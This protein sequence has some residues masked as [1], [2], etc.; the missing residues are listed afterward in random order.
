MNNRFVIVVAA[1][2]ILF[3]G[4][5]YLTKHKTTKNSGSTSN[6]QPSSHI[7]GTGSKNVTLIEYGDYECPACAAYY[8][9]LKQMVEKNK[10]DI[11]FQFRNFPLYQIHQNAFAGARA[12]EAA[13]I[14][15]KYFEM[16]DLLYENQQSWVSSSNPS[17]FFDMYAQQLGLDI[18]KFKQ[19]EA[20]DQTNNVINADI[21]AGVASGTD[22]TPTF[23]LDG[24]KIDNNP[25]DVTSFQKLIDD[26]IKA[27][28]TK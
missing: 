23:I 19:D 21:K 17:T 26:E 22:S 5:F 8:P 3:G 15:N 14:Q 27:K 2:L 18:N 25:R 12:A 10:N 20:S 16:H 7:Q 1:L 28:N 4:A 24:K 13:G 9:L 11:T 6:V